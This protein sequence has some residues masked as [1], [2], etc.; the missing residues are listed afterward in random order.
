M[1]NLIS[2]IF[3]VYKVE[4][5]LLRQS[6]ES[7][8]SQTHY[9]IE[10]LMVDDGSPDKCGIICDE[11]AHFDKRVRVF[12][13]DNHGVSAARNF[14]LDRVNGRYI[15]F[16]D[17][18]DYLEEDTFERMLYVM[19]SND[20]D[21]VQCASNHV[22]EIDMEN[23]QPEDF[24][25]DSTVLNQKQ[26]I[27]ALC[28]LEQP[29]EGYEMGAVWGA[30]YKT[31]CIGDTRFNTKMKIGEDFEFK[32]KVFLNIEFVIC[33]KAKLYNYLIREESALRNGFD[34][35]KAKSVTE[36]QE[37]LKTEFALSEYKKAL[38]SRICNIA[39]VVLF[40]IP[41]GK[42][43]DVYRK[44]IKDFLCKNRKDVIKNSKSRNKVKVS[45]ILSYFGFDFVQILFFQLRVRRIK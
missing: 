28:Y 38:Q 15:Y 27:E 12:H 23:R 4:E 13:T 32:Y 45:L 18:D 43:Y 7:V 3:P 17:S 22:Q 33:M 37:L 16:V 11:Y 20:C 26:A 30:L 25:M 44:P 36:L 5:V 42:D 19:E 24:S 2:V 29:Y 39:I 6:I 1:N 31:E 8:L 10:L 9:N 14:A 40:M 35:N 41:V 34:E 21:C